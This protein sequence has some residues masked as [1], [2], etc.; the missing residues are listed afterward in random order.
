MRGVEN[1]SGHSLASKLPSGI[2]VCVK[3]LYKR[4]KNPLIPRINCDLLRP[5]S[6]LHKS[7][8]KLRR[9]VLVERK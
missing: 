9:R 8:G 4:G 1:I 7:L 3:D 5:C 6:I 2:K